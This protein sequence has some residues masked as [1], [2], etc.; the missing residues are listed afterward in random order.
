MRGATI[1]ALAACMAGTGCTGLDDGVDKPPPKPTRAQVDR[2]I[3]ETSE[4]VY[5]FGPRYADYELSALDVQHDLV[6][7]SYGKHHCDWEGGC[8]A[9]AGIATERRSL[10]DADLSN[11]DLEGVRRPRCWSRFG[12]AVALLYGCDPGGFPQELLIFTGSR[13]ISLSS[14]DDLGDRP[15]RVVARDLEPLNERAPWPL[16]APKP[17][18][19]RELHAVPKRYRRGMPA[20][21]R[22]RGDC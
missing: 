21:L 7:F 19:C 13:V 15:A 5:W 14:I 11:V 8:T 6:V 1:A 2:L 18:S 17:L 4:P 10:R 22:P 16:A 20:A 9:P 12:R 3:A